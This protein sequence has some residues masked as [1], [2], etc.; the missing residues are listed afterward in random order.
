MFNSPFRKGMSITS[1]VLLN[2]NAD[3]MAAPNNAKY[4]L[5][6][7][8][9]GLPNAVLFSTAFAAEDLAN[10]G[11]KSHTVLT[12]I[13]SN[14]H[15][16][17]D[18][19]LALINEHLD[20]TADQGATN[21]HAGN[22]DNTQLSNEEVMDI[23]GP[24]VA[25]GGT[26]TLITVTYQDGTD[27]MD[28]VVDN[29]LANYDNSSSGF[30]TATLTNE[31]VMDIAGP[32]VA[33]GG[34]KTGIAVT[35][36]DGTDDMD[37]VVDHDGGINFVEDEHIDWTADVSPKVIHA[38]NYVDNDTTYT[39]GEGIDIVSEV[40]SGE[41]TTTSNKGIIE[42]ATEDEVQT[43]TDTVRAVVP[44]TLQSVLPPI[45][46]VM[47][48]LKS[49]T[50]TP[51]T[52]PTG[53]VEADG[54]T[55]SDADSVYDGQVLPDLRDG[56]FLRGNTTSGGTGGESTHVLTG[57]ELATH[58]HDAG[59]I[60]RFVINASSV[61]ATTSLGGTTVYT[62]TQASTAS[63]GDSDAHENKPPYYDMVWIMRIK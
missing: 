30:I 54:S 1:R 58:N 55:L 32:L 48:W 37:F 13:G 29:N 45:G 28:F 43:G 40:I 38:N 23:A 57:G 35:Y 39:A 36:Q 52:L 27:D 41:D 4:V 9:G 61:L 6:V 42:L 2:K 25:T 3:K 51:Q 47:A 63:T 46:S 34:T 8:H 16:D 59:P 12:D 7:L 10:L 33:T 26:K 49:Y 15:V 62:A 17:I 24:L 31:E 56:K 20:W 53:W 19:H 5:T 22:Y 11:T 18:S 44:D 14:S 60:T 50:S 21:I